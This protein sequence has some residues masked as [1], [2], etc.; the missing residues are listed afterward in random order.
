MSDAVT[1]LRGS[2]L[3]ILMRNNAAHI[4]LNTKL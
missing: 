3:R 2:S 1:L 4:S